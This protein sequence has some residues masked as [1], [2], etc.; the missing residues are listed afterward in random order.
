MA[1]STIGWSCTGVRNSRGKWE[2]S[3]FRS[4][5]FLLAKNFWWVS[6]KNSKYRLTNFP[7]KKTK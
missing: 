6:I 3:K 4:G 1:F 2:D 7:R 5:K